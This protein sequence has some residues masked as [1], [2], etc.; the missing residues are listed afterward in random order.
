[1][2][3]TGSMASIMEKASCTWNKEFTKE[4]FQPG[5]LMLEASMSLMINRVHIMEIGFSG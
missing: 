2:K 5:S 4:S 3:E 1:M